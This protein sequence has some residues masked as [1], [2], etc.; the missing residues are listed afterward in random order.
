MSRAFTM[1]FAIVCYAIFFATFLYLIVFVGDFALGVR[2]VD[3]G[4]Q[5]PPLTAALI[6]LALIALFG[7]QHSIMARPAFKAKWTRIVP[8][9]SERSVYVLAASIALMILFLGWRPIDTIVWNVTN[10]ALAGILWAVFWIGWLGVLISTFLINHFELFGLQQAWLNI[11]GRQADKPELKQPLFYR[12]VAHPMMSS[13]F[14]AFW[15]A[16]E[17]TAG[18]LILALGMSIYILVALR[19][20]EHDLTALFGDDYRSYRSRVGM[21]VPR[22]GRS[23]GRVAP[24]A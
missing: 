5:A 1:V 17:M 23:N 6:D 15:A 24:G 4:P 3:V 18:H 20:E 7:L 19:Y 13:F 21:L 2:T 12:W 11:S 8:R 16:P 22:L 10:P 14:L 9:A